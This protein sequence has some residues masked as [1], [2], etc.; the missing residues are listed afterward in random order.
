ME[1]SS[2]LFISLI[3]LLIAGLS[4][5]GVGSGG[6]LVIFLTSYLNVTPTDARVT[7]LIFFIFSSTGAFLIHSKRGKIKYKLVTFAALIGIIGTLIGTL[8]GELFGDATL[9]FLFGIML[10]IS[11]IYGVFGK[12][13]KCFFRNFQFFRK[14][15]PSKL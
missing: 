4:G 13:I 1:I 3:M 8:I 14:N 2:Y 15:H 6:L 12:K 7:N 9:K 5:L 10:A 11:G